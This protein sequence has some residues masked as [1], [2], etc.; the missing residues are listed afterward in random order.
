MNK[1]QRLVI[2]V[3][4]IDALIMVLFP[5]FNN[6]PLGRG[7]PE[8]F[9]GFYPLLTTFA[10]KPLN[11]ALLTIQLMFVGA[12]ALAAWLVLQTKKHHDDIPDFLYSQ[13]ILWFVAVNL[14]VVFMFPPFEPYQSLQKNVAATF[15]S[16]Y[17]VFGD[18][19][20][21][22]I[23]LPLLYLEAMWV[24]INAL[25]LWLLFNALKRNDDAARQKILALA[26]DL[27][28]E[29]LERIMAEI[30]HRIEEHHHHAPAAPEP[31][32]GPD[33]RHEHD[34][35]YRGPE[36]RSGHDRRDHHEH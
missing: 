18:R 1:Y 11:T 34:P 2:I 25:A 6:R 12:N 14:A 20:K 27:P 29:Q 15:D 28:D 21:R 22:P 10:D 9:D 7:I 30:Q 23:F 4:M 16:F 19:S 33:R 17:F 31:G 3:A 26:R 13:G 8:S 5:P 35:D 36:R 24:V 32:R